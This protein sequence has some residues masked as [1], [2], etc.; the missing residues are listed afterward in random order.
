MTDDQLIQLERHQMAMQAH[1]VLLQH[2]KY[3]GTVSLDVV[4]QARTRLDALRR[5]EE[6][7]KRKTYAEDA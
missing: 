5:L 7:A 4:E 6:F 3:P 1:G 2:A